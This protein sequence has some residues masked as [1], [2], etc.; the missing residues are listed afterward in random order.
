MFAP[1]LTKKNKCSQQAAV[2]TAAPYAET[3]ADERSLQAAKTR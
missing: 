3:A 2:A 1:N